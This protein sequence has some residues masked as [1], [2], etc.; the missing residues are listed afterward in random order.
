MK[1]L[2]FKT[3]VVLVFL[4]SL[5]ATRLSTQSEYS[6]TVI[7]EFLHDPDRGSVKI[8]SKYGKIDIQPW[9]R[10]KVKIDA[11][12]VVNTNNESNAD[13]LLGR[14]KINFTES[15]DRVTAN[16]YIEP[17]S[18]SWWRSRYDEKPDFAI[19]FKVFVPTLT[20]VQI[21]LQHGDLTMG[22]LEGAVDVLLKIGKVN[23]KT[24]GRKSFFLFEFVNGTIGEVPDGYAELSDSK[25][26]FKQAG[27]LEIRSTKSKIAIDKVDE[28]RTHTKYDDYNIRNA[29]AVYNRGAYDEMVIE[30][31]NDL[32]VQSGNS[33]FLI[34]RFYETMDIDLKKGDLVV[35]QVVPGFSNLNLYGENASFEVTL[36]KGCSYVLD[37]DAEYAGIKYPPG[38]QIE[39]EKL[40]SSR[41]LIKGRT[42]G[43]V[44]GGNIFAR[45]IYGGLKINR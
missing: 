31:V 6:K 44:R 19:Y 9:D 37:G 20:K 34:G 21:N 16:S 8:S 18:R 12:I 3:S 43:P 11:K 5:I 29:G 25:I 41:H 1:G 22:Q 7:R 39:S 28:L 10:S 40:S 26:A 4:C 36:G 2:Q 17:D 30:Q 32:K 42:P 14:I 35:Q 24:V 38:L 23:I 27:S 45:L 15:T 33:D 13:R